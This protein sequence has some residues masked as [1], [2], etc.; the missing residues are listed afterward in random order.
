MP[1]C[2][3]VFKNDLIVGCST[4]EVK[5]F[6]CQFGTG[7]QTLKTHKADIKCMETSKNGVIFLAQIYATGLD[8]RI[9]FI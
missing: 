9:A 5:I 6:E 4:G 7:T 3:K 1:W 8:S 2:L